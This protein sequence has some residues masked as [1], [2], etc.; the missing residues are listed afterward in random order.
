MGAFCRFPSVLFPG[1][2]CQVPSSGI[3][4]PS[5]YFGS[6]LFISLLPTLP[7]GSG[8]A[9]E[10]F[11][12]HVFTIFNLELESFI[13]RHSCI[14]SF[15]GMASAY[16]NDLIDLFAVSTILSHCY[17]RSVVSRFRTLVTLHCLCFQHSCSDC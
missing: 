1:S 12:N 2:R 6:E 17:M 8:I 9:E 15:G 4:W 5:R 13:I 10:G 11:E 7:H 14:G 3:G 16:S